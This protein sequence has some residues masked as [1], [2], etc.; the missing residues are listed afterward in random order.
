MEN[1]KQ[2]LPADVVTVVNLR[3]YFFLLLAEELG[4]CAK[5]QIFASLG[6]KKVSI[7]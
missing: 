6:L 4:L 5:N 7:N 1:N 3:I 2:F